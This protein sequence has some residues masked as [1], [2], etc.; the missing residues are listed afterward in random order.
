MGRR[1]LNPGQSCARQIPL[2]C[3]IVP[4]QLAS[5]NFYRKPIVGKW[6][7]KL[8]DV[9]VKTLLRRNNWDMV[10]KYK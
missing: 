7:H 5:T 10:T 4:A 8:Q 6:Q 3:A 2:C 9:N 1:G